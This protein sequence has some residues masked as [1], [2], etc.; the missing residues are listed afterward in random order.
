M[1]MISSC[2]VARKNSSTRIRLLGRRLRTHILHPWTV[3][4]YLLTMYV[5]YY[6]ARIVSYKVIFYA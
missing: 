3:E 2:S 5:L 6:R 4:Y 1:S